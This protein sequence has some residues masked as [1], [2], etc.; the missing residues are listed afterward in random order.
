VQEI[1]GL[2]DIGKLQAIVEKE[3]PLSEAAFAHELSETGH[4][5]G[6]IILTIG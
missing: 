5:L 2:I 3:F 6:K 1:A 4:V